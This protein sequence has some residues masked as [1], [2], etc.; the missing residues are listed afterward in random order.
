MNT[1][2][3]QRNLL[4]H[5]HFSFQNSTFFTLLKHENGL[6]SNLLFLSSFGLFLFFMIFQ[7]TTFHL[8]R[9]EFLWMLM[10][11]NHSFPEN[12]LGARKL[13]RCIMVLFIYIIVYFYSIVYSHGY[14]ILLVNNWFCEV[15][16]ID[17]LFYKSF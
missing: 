3:M 7:F 13:K 16:S 6:I 8:F 12:D 2:S 5:L 9:C 17:I 15:H 11:N 10:D 4:Y 1:H 14:L